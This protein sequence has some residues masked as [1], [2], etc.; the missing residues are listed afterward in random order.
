VGYNSINYLSVVPIKKVKIDK[1]IVNENSNEK[2][3]FLKNIIK[4]VHSLDLAVV[5]EGIENEREFE[6]LKEYDCDFAQGYYL[7]RPTSIDEI[8]T[9]ISED[10]VAKN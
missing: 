9:L 3:I 2:N 7:S 8:K 4:I 6:R 5:V 1:C 10:N